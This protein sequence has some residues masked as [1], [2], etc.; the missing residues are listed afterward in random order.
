MKH[1]INTLLLHEKL[2]DIKSSASRVSQTESSA[3]VLF[4]NLP[5]GWVVIDSL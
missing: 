3:N 5:E 1:H 4:I 2:I